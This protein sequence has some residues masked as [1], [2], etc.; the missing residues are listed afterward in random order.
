MQVSLIVSKMA[1]NLEV[2]EYG[3]ES[4]PIRQKHLQPTSANFHRH[5]KIGLC[6]F[7]L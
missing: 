5:T 6:M 1:G 4:L 3:Y 2:H 7:K